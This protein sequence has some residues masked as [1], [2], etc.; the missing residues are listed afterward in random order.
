[1]YRLTSHLH[2]GEKTEKFDSYDKLTAR[3]SH[4]LAADLTRRQSGKGSRAKLLPWTP[5]KELQARLDTGAVVGTTV[6]GVLVVVKRS[7]VS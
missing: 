3:L 7:D 2:R 5:P 1:M 4:V 6:N